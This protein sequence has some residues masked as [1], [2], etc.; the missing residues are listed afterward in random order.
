[1]AG[2]VQFNLAR[3]G[4]RYFTI[5]QLNDF[6]IQYFKLK[7]KI[8]IKQGMPLVAVEADPTVLNKSFIV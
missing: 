6:L 4:H 7:F 3:H 2:A 1:M 8:K 5:V